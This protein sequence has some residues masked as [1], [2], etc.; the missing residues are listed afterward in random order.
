MWCKGISP[1]TT[2]IYNLGGTLNSIVSCGGVAVK[3]GDVVLADDS[4]V[5]VLPLEDADVVA[6]QALAMQERGRVNEGRVAGGEKL[7][8]ISGATRMVE[9]YLASAGRK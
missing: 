4:G 3:P 1:I 2:R 8:L 5:L 9:E 7:G 6:D